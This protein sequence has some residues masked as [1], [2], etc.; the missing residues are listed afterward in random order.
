MPKNTEFPAP[1]RM[2]GKLL[3]EQFEIENFKRALI[4]LE[5]LERDETKSIVFMTAKQIS[6]ELPYQRRALGKMVEGRVRGEFPGPTSKAAPVNDPALR[7][8]AAA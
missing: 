2:G 5:P 4:G 8:Q 1:I 3:W 7:D 6:A